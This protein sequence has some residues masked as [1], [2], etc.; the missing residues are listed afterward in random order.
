MN[1]IN[2]FLSEPKTETAFVL[3]TN[4]NLYIKKNT[5]PC[6]GVVMCGGGG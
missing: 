3:Y 4:R 2:I 5:F 1:L 6:S